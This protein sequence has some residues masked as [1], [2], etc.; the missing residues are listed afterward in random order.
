ME[1]N[2][3]SKAV[4]LEQL[5]NAHQKS[6]KKIEALTQKLE[7]VATASVSGIEDAM[8]QVATH[9]RYSPTTSVTGALADATVGSL[10]D[11][12]TLATLTSAG[13]D[14][15]G[16]NQYAFLINGVQTGTYTKDSK[17]SA[18]LDGINSSETA[19]VNASYDQET[20]RFTFTA[21]KAGKD[22]RIEMGEGLADAMFGPPASSDKSGESITA[23]YDFGWL[24]DGNSEEIHVNMPAYTIITTITKET[25]IQELITK[26]NNGAM[27]TETFYYNKYTGG[28]EAREKDTGELLDVTI[29]DSDDLEYPA[30]NNPV[31]YTTGVDAIFTAIEVNGNK[32]P[33]SGKTVNISVPTRVS[34]LENNS[35]F[36]T[37][38]QVAAAIN[39]K[40]S[41]AYKAGGSVAFAALPAPDEA[42]LG[43]VY[44]VTDKFT[45]TDAFVDGAGGK[46]P[47]GTNV[48]IVAVTDG[49]TTSY[50]YDVLSGFVDLSGYQAAEE[51]KGLSSN[52]FTDAAKAKLDSIT[53]AT[54]AEVAAALAEIYGPE[55][56]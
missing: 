27:G 38:E 3:N 6:S 22:Q 17:L 32:M 40:V 35:K 49:E 26:L 53:F 30:R 9:T 46:H 34:Q 10:V 44:N 28:I 1:T 33:V 47:A 13:T 37:E 16:S 39:A 19:G 48:A 20:N 29:L 14:D 56:A 42:H 41:C 15:A 50:K 21:R 52:D 36:Q 25:T 54:D 5:I 45:T 2:T 8:Y 12:E 24:D 43:F 55:E 31:D 18:V 7:T 51:G 23:V 11:D 4:T